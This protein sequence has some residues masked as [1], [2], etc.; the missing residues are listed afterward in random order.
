MTMRSE[1]AEGVEKVNK[2]LLVNSAE[3]IDYCVHAS[4]EKINQQKG[5]RENPLNS[6]IN[7]TW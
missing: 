3:R 1:N 6:E 2:P 7:S 4:K 5:K